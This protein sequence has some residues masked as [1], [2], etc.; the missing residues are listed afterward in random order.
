M[1]IMTMH[2]FP[3]LV[4]QDK[5]WYMY[6]YLR[7]PKKIKV[8]TLTTWLI[9]LNNYLPYFSPDCVGQMVTALPDDKVKKIL[10]RALPNS[11]K[12][13]MTKQ[14]YNYLTKI[15]QTTQAGGNSVIIIRSAVILWTNAL[16]SRP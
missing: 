15:S 3:M 5:K 11:W 1:A 4:Y 7:K 2:I 8:S 10:C 12:K 9:Q 16:H 14:G 6:R 13:K